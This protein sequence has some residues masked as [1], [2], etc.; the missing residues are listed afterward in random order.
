MLQKNQKLP[1]YTV[2]L[3]YL[4]QY[5]SFDVNLPTYTSCAKVWP[6]RKW[7]IHWFNIIFGKV[8]QKVKSTVIAKGILKSLAVI[9]CIAIL[10][11]VLYQIQSLIMYCIIAAFIALLAR[12]IVYFLR[13]KLKFANIIAVVTTM[14]FIIGIFVGLAAL[15]VPVISD[16]SDNFALFDIETIQQKVNDLFMKIS[17]LLGASDEV[18]EEIMDDANIEDNVLDNLE[19]GFIPKLFATILNLL[20][21]IG[22]GV[23]SVIFISFFFL[24][25]SQLIQKLILQMVPLSHQKQTLNSISQTKNLLSSYFVGIIIQMTIIFVFYAAGLL[26]AGID[27]ALIIALFCAMFNV[28]PYVGPLIGGSLMLLLAITSNLDMDFNTVVVQK[29]IYVLVAF[30]IGQLVDNFFSQPLIFSNKMKSHPL[31]I[32]LVIVATGLMFGVVGMIIAVPLYT[33]IKVVLKEFTSEIRIVDALTKD[34]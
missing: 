2:S 16:Q 1:Q 12:P 22:V 6:S 9:V 20:S 18:V 19:V 5:F 31:E 27:N 25:D 4:S 13:R 7:K 30:I 14:L 34:M 11:W 8:T 24:K 17:G 23:F 3:G 10:V 32:F 29:T 26:I 21:S 28:I 33:V 15:F